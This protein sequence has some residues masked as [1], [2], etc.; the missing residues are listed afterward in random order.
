MLWRLFCVR[1]SSAPDAAPESLTWSSGSPTA[2][3]NG[4]HRGGLA[5]E[6]RRF[7]RPQR[8]LRCRRER[9]RAHENGRDK[10]RNAGGSEDH[11]HDDELVDA[12]VNGTGARNHHARH[13]SGNPHQ[14]E[15][16]HHVEP[17]QKACVDGALKIG[18]D[19]DGGLG[20]QRQS[21]FD[22]ADMGKDLGPEALDG[23]GARIHRIGN[24]H[25]AHRDKHRNLG[26][27]TASREHHGDDG[28]GAGGYRPETQQKCTV[29]SLETAGG[30]D[31][32]GDRHH[33]QDE[34]TDQQMALGARHD[35]TS[36]SSHVR[37]R[38]RV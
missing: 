29:H 31:R 33:E 21:C 15:R 12:C 11:R 30:R 16:L 23:L 1:R 27:E 17:G 2:P 13:D 37:T 19:G 28:P 22:L 20:P 25:A 4:G 7:C 36:F 34:G 26:P 8:E 14:P 32:S 35:R 38:D 10:T 5:A 3:G 9:S 18:R 24:D 6:G